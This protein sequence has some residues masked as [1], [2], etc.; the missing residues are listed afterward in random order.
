MRKR[1]RAFN[2][3]PDCPAAASEHFN[4]QGLG[5]RLQPW[6][7]LLTPRDGYVVLRF[8]WVRCSRDGRSV[9]RGVYSAPEWVLE[10]LDRR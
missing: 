2:V 9:V 5:Y 1:V 4:L 7:R 8:C 10:W 3:L 6:A